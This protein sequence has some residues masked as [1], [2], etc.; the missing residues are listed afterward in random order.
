MPKFIPIFP[1]SVVVFPTEKLNLHIFESQYKQLVNDCLEQQKPFGIVPVIG[2]K[3]QDHG[4]LIYIEEVAQL[5]EDGRMDIRTQADSVFKILELTREIPDKLYSGAI[6]ADLP[7]A[8]IEIS[9]RLSSLITSEVIR[10]YKLLSETGIDIAK[11]KLDNSFDIAHKIGLSLEEEYQLLQL[12]NETH[13]QE[14]I[15]RHLKKLE[16]IL[17]ELEA[18]KEKIKMNGH[19][20]HLSGSDFF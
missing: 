2:G 3:I 8:K 6:V 20:R 14:F 16:P 15:R 18:I 9:E 17:N 5:Y 1:L 7:Q 4:T 11:L 13:R 10:L 12:E 19:F